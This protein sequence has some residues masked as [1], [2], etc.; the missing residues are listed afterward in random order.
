MAPEFDHLAESLDD[1]TARITSELR[2][3]LECAPSE[4]DWLAI[5]TAIAKATLEG[6]RRGAEEIGAQVDEAVPEGQEVSWNLD[7]DCTDL[8]AQ[9]YGEASSRP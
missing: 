7:L 5:S 9:R 8:W 6:L 3:R 2:A 4:K 1:A